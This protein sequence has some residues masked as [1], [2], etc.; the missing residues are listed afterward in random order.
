VPSQHL[1]CGC[2][3]AGHH[4][5]PPALCLRAVLLLSTTKAAAAAAAITHASAWHHGLQ[6]LPQARVADSD[7]L[8]CVLG[9]QSPRLELPPLHLL[10]QAVEAGVVKLQYLGECR[11]VRRG[12]VQVQRR[13]HPL[14]DVICK[15]KADVYVYLCLAEFTGTIYPSYMS[16]QVS[17][18]TSRSWFNSVGSTISAYHSLTHSPLKHASVIIVAVG[19][20]STLH[21]SPQ[22]VGHCQPPV[23]TQHGM[24][25]TPD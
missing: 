12:R 1:P 19:S 15:L 11:Q 4:Q 21:P 22:L 9:M 16:W 3:S 7:G 8:L 10:K 6:L 17:P 24:L 2:C 23:H 14:C 5:C 20:S 25:S 18:H 13:I